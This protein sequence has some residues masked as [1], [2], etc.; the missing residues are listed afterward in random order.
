MVHQERFPIFG[1]SHSTAF[2]LYHAALLIW[3]D[4]KSV[5]DS[6]SWPTSPEDVDDAKEKVPAYPYNLLARVLVGDSIAAIPTE[7]KFVEVASDK[8][9]C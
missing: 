1:I 7:G 6:M 3:S 8:D 9:H 2:G 4:I 5:K